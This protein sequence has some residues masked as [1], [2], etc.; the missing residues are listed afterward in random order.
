MRESTLHYF[1]HFA[2]KTARVGSK[3]FALWSTGAANSHKSLCKEGWCSRV[4]HGT[5]VALVNSVI[6]EDHM[7]MLGVIH[8]ALSWGGLPLRGTTLRHRTVVGH[9]TDMST[10][11]A[12]WWCPGSVFTTTTTTATTSTTTTTPTTTPPTFITHLSQKWLSRLEN[13]VWT[14]YYDDRYYF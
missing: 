3:H 1:A 11:Q 5:A 12:C 4:Q 9:M 7:A 14:R 8:R 6:R 2:S 13:E 10:L